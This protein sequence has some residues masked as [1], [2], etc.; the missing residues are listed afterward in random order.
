MPCR[1]ASKRCWGSTALP[2]PVHAEEHPTLMRIARRCSRRAFS[3]G[4]K[5]LGRFLT[6]IHSEGFYLNNILFK[7]FF[8]NLV[9]MF[10]AISAWHIIL[11]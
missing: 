4:L 1:A 9:F 8:V 11:L 7:K 2:D 5:G 3:C 6:A 10:T